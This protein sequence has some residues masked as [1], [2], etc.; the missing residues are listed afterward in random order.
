MEQEAEAA[1][2]GMPADAGVYSHLPPGAARGDD[3]EFWGVAYEPTLKRW[4][5]PFIMQV[6][7]AL[8]RRRLV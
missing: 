4:L 1:K 5:A 3:G 2:R 8:S 7:R 6:G